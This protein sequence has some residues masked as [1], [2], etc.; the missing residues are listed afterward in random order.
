M[1]KY[2]LPEKTCGQCIHEHACQAWNIGHLH[3]ADASSCVNYETVKDSAAYYIGF[4]DGK[5]ENPGE[6]G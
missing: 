6:K 1:A 4:L 2:K 5:K 3:D